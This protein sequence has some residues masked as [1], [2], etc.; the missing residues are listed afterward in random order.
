MA[1]QLGIETEVAGNYPKSHNK[2]E[3]K[4]AETIREDRNIEED[5]TAPLVWSAVD[6]EGH[7]PLASAPVAGDE[8]AFKTDKHTFLSHVQSVNGTVAW[9]LPY[10]SSNGLELNVDDNATD[11]I[12]GWEFTHSLLSGH[13]SAYTVGSFPE[14]DKKVFFEVAF[15]ETDISDITK[16]FVGWRKAEAFQA[17]IDDYDELAAIGIDSSANIDIITILNNAAT[18][19]TDTT[20]NKTEGTAITLKVV[21]DND[22]RVEFLLNGA[23]PTTVPAQFTF[24]SGEVL[25]PFVHFVANTGDPGAYISSWKCGAL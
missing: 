8:I 5:F 2:R 22:G 20:D 16:L 3:L 10:T 7:I 15:N 21:V 23:A 9:A 24:D 25:I 13:K 19:T 18:S 17:D 11:G 6:Q 4:L 12:L 14:P 1:N